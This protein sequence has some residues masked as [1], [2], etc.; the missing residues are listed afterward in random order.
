MMVLKEEH[1]W[2]EPAVRGK[3]SPLVSVGVSPELVPERSA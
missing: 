1:R 2:T 3:N